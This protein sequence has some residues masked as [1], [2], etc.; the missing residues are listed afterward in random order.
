M[1]TEA[2]AAPASAATSAGLPSKTASSTMDLRTV[3]ILRFAVASTAAAAIAF[4]FEW[5]LFFLMPVL[6]MAFLA[7][8]IPGFSRQKWLLV[9]YAAGAVTLG[10]IFT[11]FLQPYPMVYLLLLGLALFNI[12]Y[13]LNRG[14]PFIFA[15]MSLL[16]VIILPLMSIA[17]EQLALVFAFY[18]G[19][20]ACLAIVIV[21][22]ARGLFP[23]PPGT[24]ARPDHVFHPGYS[25]AAAKKSLIST[26]A[27]LPLVL[28]FVAFEF[29]GGLLTAVYAGLL[30]LSADPAAGWAG[31][32]KSLRS[33]LLGCIA[34]IV[35]YWLLVAVPEMHFFLVLWFVTMLIFASFIFS[36]HPLSKYMGSAA[37]AMTILVSGSL[38]PEADF[39][40]KMIVRVILICGAA[41]YVAAALAF[42]DRYLFRTREQA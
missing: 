42:I 20:S 35:V 5:P 38:G 34:A 25:E 24:P 36:D 31:G 30:S 37:I 15:L 7:N 14:G 41:L 33:T 2:M 11:L 12:Y 40:G 19:F 10:L 4:A 26:I 39:V 13:L 17:A 29:Q 3:R 6:T 18:F 21:L 23:D 32:M 8:D 1:S 28:L 22:I 27:V 16:A 9:S